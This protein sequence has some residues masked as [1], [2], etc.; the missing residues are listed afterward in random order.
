[1]HAFDYTTIMLYYTSKGYVKPKNSGISG[2]RLLSKQMRLR[3]AL[4]I[5]VMTLFPPLVINSG[6][7]NVFDIE[8]LIRQ[9]KREAAHY[10]A[11]A[12]SNVESIVNSIKSKK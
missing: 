9:Y 8:D 1:M 5:V 3:T 12:R 7:S 11:L 10:E 4:I 6:G 2:K